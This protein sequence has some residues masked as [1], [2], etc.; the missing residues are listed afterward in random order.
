MKHGSDTEHVASAFACSR[1]CS[2]CLD[3]V[4]RL[5]VVGPIAALSL[6]ASKR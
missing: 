2:L 6:I 1:H 5:R 3:A 4:A